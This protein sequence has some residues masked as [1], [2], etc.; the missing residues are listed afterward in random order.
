VLRGGDAIIGSPGDTYTA[1]LAEREP[2]P[3]ES[4]NGF[5]RP[6]ATY[7]V[8]YQGRKVSKAAFIAELESRPD[9]PY[10]QAMLARVKSQD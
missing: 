8:D 9:D 5:N 2:G 4:G 1:M 7:V 10:A 6:E 3:A